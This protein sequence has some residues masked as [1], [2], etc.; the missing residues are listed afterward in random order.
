MNERRSGAHTR[1]E[2][3]RITAVLRYVRRDG[4]PTQEV[5]VRHAAAVAARHAGAPARGGALDPAR[6]CA[7]REVRAG[8]VCI[9]LVWSCEGRR[10]DV[11]V[12]VTD[13]QVAAARLL[14]HVV[15]RF[16]PDELAVHVD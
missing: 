14:E 6:P 1:P 5:A 3:F 13:R 2:A 7:A 10:L 16:A 15:T 11:G 9:T 12:V 8:P 4:A